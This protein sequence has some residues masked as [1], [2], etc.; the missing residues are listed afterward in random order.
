MLNLLRERKK[1]YVVTKDG[2]F[3]KTNDEMSSI[4]K[5]VYIE[6]GSSY[7]DKKVALHLSSICL[8]LGIYCRVVEYL[9]TYVPV[10]K[11]EG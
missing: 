10:E 3:I 6:D 8:E 7:Y 11:V 5:V 1:Y 4:E 9:I 2:W